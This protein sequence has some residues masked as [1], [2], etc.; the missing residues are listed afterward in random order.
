MRRVLAIL[1][2]ALFLVVAPGTV[3]GLIPWWISGWRVDEPFLGL[4]A[5]RGVGVFLVAAGLLVQLDTFSRF[6]LQR[7]VSCARWRGG[8]VVEGG[9]LEKR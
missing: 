6:A 9:A 3:A 1:G 8:R 5:V 7:A 2:S 4:A